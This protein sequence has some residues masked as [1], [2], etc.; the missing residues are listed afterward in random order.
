MKKQHAENVYGSKLDAKK[1]IA[2][3]LWPTLGATALYL[4]PV[5]LI[6]AALVAVCGGT[7]TEA[8]SKLSDQQLMTYLGVYLLAHFF[9]VQPLYYGLTQ[10]YA[11]QR[12][13]ARPSVSTVT[14]C[15][16]SFRLYFRALRLTLVILLFSVLWAIPLAI[17]CGAGFALYYYV[18]PGGFG[19]FVCIEII[20]I[21]MIAYLSAVMRY[22]CAYALIT[23][24]PEL[25][26]WAAVRQ[27]ARKFRGH[28]GEMLSLMVSFMLWYILTVM[29]GG[30]LLIILCPYVLLS[31]YHLFDRIRGVQIK[32][33]PKETQ[34][35]ESKGE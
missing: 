11:L 15:L 19:W 32:V 28:N 33:M 17:V 29:I 18:L 22:H 3:M 24:Q 35:D 21:A 34:Q 9:I 6:S 23:E 1:D 31:V 12:A 16:T 2:A 4:L 20:I 13:G 27:T 8:I 25:G 30:L 26:C 10:F 7:D 5:V 14:M